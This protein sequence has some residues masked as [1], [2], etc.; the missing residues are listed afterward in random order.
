MAPDVINNLPKPDVAFLGGT[1]GNMEQIL[2]I[3]TTKKSKDSF[4]N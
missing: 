4:S 3:F 2:T 1:K